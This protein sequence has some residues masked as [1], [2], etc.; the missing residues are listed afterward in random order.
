MALLGLVLQSCGQVSLP[1]LAPPL[2]ALVCCYS[3]KHRILPQ[4]HPKVNQRVFA[5]AGAFSPGTSHPQ[6]PHRYHL[7]SRWQQSGSVGHL[8]PQGM[9]GKRL[10]GA[11]AEM[12]AGRPRLRPSGVIALVMQGWGA[13]V[14]LQFLRQHDR[15][16]RRGAEA[17]GIA[18]EREEQD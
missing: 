12:A 3:S 1:V 17:D 14:R 7:S 16:A 6:T 13:G 11:A 2:K 18:P 4:Q 10:W 5:P 15:M 9:L 8:E